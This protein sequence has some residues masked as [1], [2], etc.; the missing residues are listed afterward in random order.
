MPTAGIAA[1]TQRRK[2]IYARREVE[3][4]GY[5]DPGRFHHR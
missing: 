3:Q 2:A 1:L 4:S 5:V